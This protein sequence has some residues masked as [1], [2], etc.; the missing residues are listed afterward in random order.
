MPTATRAKVPAATEANPPITHSKF[1]QVT[2]PAINLTLGFF[3][4]ISGF[5]SQLD[6]QEYPEGGVNT[7]VHK[8]PGRIKQGNITLK[9]GITKESA[10]IHW[11]E[12]SVTALEPTELT[13]HV[14]DYAGDVVQTWTF[15][16]AY[17]VKWSGTDLNAGGSEFL[18]QSLEIAHLGM[19][20]V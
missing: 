13:I 10:L 18:T 1:F 15:D 8:L 12:K 6:V 16:G 17:P 14:L 19:K 5:S 20:V 9:R 2:I 3:T 4:Q 7:F 11:Y